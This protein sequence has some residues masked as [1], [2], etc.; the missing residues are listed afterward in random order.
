[1][2]PPGVPFEISQ[3]VDDCLPYLEGA[4]IVA[5]LQYNPPSTLCGALAAWAGAQG[6]GCVADCGLVL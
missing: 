1:M 6:P 5:G 3:S 2:Q 4:S